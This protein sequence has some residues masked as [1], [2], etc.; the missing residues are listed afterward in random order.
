MAKDAFVSLCNR[1]CCINAGCCGLEQAV[2]VT[3]NISAMP[4]FQVYK[5]GEMA[6]ELVGASKE[7]LQSLVAKYAQIASPQQALLV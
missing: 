5:D 1:Q 3:A 6:E 7:R 4:T 2:A